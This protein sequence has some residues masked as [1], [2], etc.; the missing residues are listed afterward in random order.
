MGPARPGF[1]RWSRVARRSKSK[2]PAY[3]A[4]ISDLHLSDVEEADPAH[5]LWKRHKQTDLIADGRLESL[6]A[7]LRALSHGEPIELVLNGDI[8]DFD[9]VAVVPDPA[10]WPVS[11]IERLRGLLPEEPKSEW[12]LA[13]IV[14]HHPLFLGALRVWLSE[15]HSLVFVIGNHDLELHWPAC[16]AVL[17]E[18]LGEPEQLRICEFYTISHHDTLI[19]HGNQYDAY[20]VVHDPLH[21]FVEV[22][23]KARVRLP[24]GDQAARLMMNGLGLFNPHVDDS[25]R[26]PLLEHVGWFV[27]LVPRHHPTIAWTWFWSSLATLWVSVGEGFRPAIRDPR[28]LAA[29][30]AAVSRRARGSSTVT[31]ALAAVAVHPAVFDPIKVARELWLDRAFLLAALIFASVQ[32]FSA[33]RMVSGA[34]ATGGL[35]AFIVLLVPFVRYARSCRSSVGEAEIEI[36]ERVPTLA[37]IARV[38]RVIMGHTHRARREVVHGVEYFNTGHWSPAY[39]D[40]A[41]TQPLGR[42][43]F[44]WLA[45]APE[46]PRTAE[47]RVFADGRSTVYAPSEAP[48]PLLAHLGAVRT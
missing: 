7:H 21:P 8:F 16:Q 40:A 13:R 17:R 25:L 23:G 14:S 19:T 1:A 36:R 22:N 10:P 12:K 38:K 34:G 41:C 45:P 30:E 48:P 33:S 29:R 43:A 37:Q 18:A 5:P 20:C 44:A 39:A 26:R 11:R 24:F 27:R 35:L 6:L 3:T 2:V 9:G 31:R 42:N 46:G 47:L 28:D 32:V 15:G 4:V